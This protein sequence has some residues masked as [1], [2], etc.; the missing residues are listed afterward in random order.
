M[1]LFKDFDR[2]SVFDR[3]ESYA[4]LL[5]IRN[6][7]NAIPHDVHELAELRRKIV[8][9]LLALTTDRSEADIVLNTTPHGKRVLPG[10]TFDWSVSHSSRHLAFGLSF[11]SR[12]GIDIEDTSRRVSFDDIAGAVFTPRESEQSRTPSDFYT[13]WTAKESLMKAVGL[14]F[15]FDPKRFSLA[16]GEDGI[17]AEDV[18]GYRKEDFHFETTLE[19]PLRLCVC[20]CPATEGFLC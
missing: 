6:L 4:W 16:I 17:A 11:D 20:R 3:A 7:R 8:R 14:G 15:A 18:E 5:D 19:R 10:A 1:K 12:I 13:I 9:R 2:P